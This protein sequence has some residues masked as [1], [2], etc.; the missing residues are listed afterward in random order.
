MSYITVDSSTSSTTVLIFDEKLKILKKF[1]KEH[2][3]IIT[4]EGYVEHNLEEIYQ[5]LLELVKKASDILTKPK[6]ISITNQRETFTLFNKKDGKPVHNA[7]VWQCT[8]GQNICEEILAD[9]SKRKIIVNK[10]GLKPNT[11]F[12]GSK[13]KWVYDEKEKIR[14]KVD[15]GEILFGTIETYL[16][17]R[18]TNMKSYISDTTNA[19]R[20]LLFNCLN[21]EWDQELLNIFDIKK[22]ELPKVINS[23]NIFGESDFNKAFNKTI[24]IIGVAGDAQAS[25]FANFCFKKGDT[26]ITT[27]TGFNIQ[28]NIGNK[29]FIDEKSLTSLAFTYENRNIYALECLN[30]YAGGTISWLKNNLGLIKAV[31]ESEFFSKKEKDNNGVYLIPAFSGLGPPYWNSEARAAFFGISASTNTNHL[32]RAGLESVAYQ[33]VVY[34]EFMKKSHNMELNNLSIDGGMVKNKFFLQIIS[35]LLKIDLNIPEMEEM[36]SYGALLFGIQY[37]HNIKNLDDLKDFKVK[38]S[39]IK[40]N[41]NKIINQ[42]YLSWKEIVDKHFIKNQG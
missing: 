27:G 14:K 29:M 7:I 16:I 12:S 20:T 10:T 34:L 31:E 15:N 3:Q 5:N 41:T 28:T 6:F 8:R 25:L 40:P 9:V 11:F 2:S 33:M 36:S 24:P 26:K 4:D 42:S 1:Q 22:I 32:I 19:S 35:D 39:V 18:L 23:S 37:F 38:K 13:L 17:Y 21:N 30:S